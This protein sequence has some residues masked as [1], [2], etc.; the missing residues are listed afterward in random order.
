M[1]RR[2]RTGL[3][4]REP[5]SPTAIRRRQF[6]AAVGGGILVSVVATKAVGQE[7]TTPAAA[8]PA[9]NAHLRVG[10]DGRVTCFVGKI[11]MGQ[12]IITSLPMVMAEEL[13]VPLS[14]VDVVAGDT[15]LCPYD[16][17]T[18]GS[19]S[20]QQYANGLRTAAAQ[21]KAVLKQMGAE[22][23][24]VLV[25]DV[26]VADGAVFV[27][28]D[29]NRRVTYAE[30][31]KG[32]Q[33]LRQVTG[34]AP[35]DPVSAY[36]IV[37][38]PTPRTDAVAKV[39]GQAKYAGD[40][41]LPGMLYASILRPPSLGATRQSLDTSAAEAV[42]GVTVVNTGGLVA[43]LHEQPDV[44][45][46]AIGLVKATWKENSLA[47][48]DKAIFDYYERSLGSL[49][50]VTGV[51][52]V[53]TAAQ[54]AETTIENRFLGGYLAHAPME[55]H[56]ALADYKDGQITVW[57][58][59]QNPFGVRDEVAAAVGLPASKVR[60]ITPFVGGGFGGKS[61][62]GQAIEAARLSKAVG[63]PVMVAWS[64]EEELTL[65][66]YRPAAV[67]IVR[68]GLKAGKV[69]FFDMGIYGV[70]D[71]GT[72]LFYSFPNY[73]VRTADDRGVPLPTGPWRGPGNNANTFARECQMD[74]MAAKL[75]ADPVQFRLDH[76]SNNARMRAVLEA[77]A[78]Q[79]G[80]QTARF[81]SG[82][83]YGVAL[84][85]DAGT[86]VAT[87]MEV[88]VDGATGKVQV[89][90]VVCAQDMGLV[91]NPQGAITQMEGCTN[92]GLGYSFGEELR[93]QGTKVLD[94]SFATYRIPTFM[95]VPPKIET[96]LV[97]S[98]STPAHGGGEPAIVTVGAAA[99]NAIFDATG[100]RLYQLPMTPE[101]VL[102]AIEKARQE[103]PAPGLTGDVNA[104]GKVTTADAM[105]AVQ[106]ALGLRT[107][108]EAQLRAAD[109]DGSG[110]VEVGDALRILRA[111]VG[112]G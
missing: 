57:A 33:I 35:V 17:G 101:R 104:D 98:R 88:K 94:R 32:Q 21:A 15:A 103:G 23:L 66:H 86:Y 83:G 5:S 74:I 44:A 26:S 107:G 81:P 53:T 14:S 106:L 58:S 16:A 4:R 75:G 91:V 13:E 30:L 60:I 71:R 27:T 110:K 79:F 73:R 108:T 54:Q 102:A 72:D 56:T 62:N 46:K 3:T 36:T 76:L 6:L 42:P 37:G 68:S 93:F 41:H 109:T 34:S 28:A 7:A 19:L 84:G 105:L 97:N 47:V 20:I 90:R 112:G 69:I 63:K 89:L 50:Q 10:A 82:R 61:S 43:A 95:D 31:T 11:E 52:S 12:G 100:A 65:D 22:Q 9:F 40:M 25:A 8:A 51:G 67:H 45:A 18:W 78:K 111:A 80:W 99:A 2:V 48:D 59:T 92:M 38:K 87:I 24:G 55:P 96:V 77:A 49:R 29:P 39:T 70:G 64:R 1:A 85:S